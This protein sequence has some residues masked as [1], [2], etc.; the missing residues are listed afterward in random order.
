M[1]CNSVQLR[2]K[3]FKRLSKVVPACFRLLPSNVVRCR[4]SFQNSLLNDRQTDGLTD[5]RAWCHAAGRVKGTRVCLLVRQLRIFGSGLNEERRWRNEK[6]H[7][8]S[9]GSRAAS[10]RSQRQRRQPR[11]HRGGHNSVQVLSSLTMTVTGLSS[12]CSR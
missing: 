10:R 12:T 2:W 5:D 3:T 7:G 9:W 4:F 6:A 11:N 1:C 8:G